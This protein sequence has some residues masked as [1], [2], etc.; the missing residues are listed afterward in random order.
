MEAV[1]SEVRLGQNLSRVNIRLLYPCERANPHGSGTSCH[2][3]IRAERL[4]ARIENHQVVPISWAL[5]RLYTWKVGGRLEQG[6]DQGNGPPK[7]PGNRPGD[8]PCR[9]GGPEGARHRRWS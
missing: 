9:A 2:F 8:S 6:F 5:T 3:S 7:P 1:V 4:R